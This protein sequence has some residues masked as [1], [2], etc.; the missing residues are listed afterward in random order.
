MLTVCI[1]AA[2]CLPQIEH[3]VRLSYRSSG[4]LRFLMRICNSVTSL[5]IS[6]F[7]LQ[8]RA[9]CF[10]PSSEWSVLSHTRGDGE[11]VSMTV[12]ADMG[13][14]VVFARPAADEDDEDRSTED[15]DQWFQ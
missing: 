9:E 12:F 7:I 13:R 5:L 6:R 4:L 14:S 2:K 3:N 11:I 8:M 10:S 15:G 1:Q